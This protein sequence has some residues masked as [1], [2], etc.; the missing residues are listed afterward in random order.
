MADIHMKIGHFGLWTLMSAGQG[1]R[2]DH[3]MWV[4]FLSP[5]A[6]EDGWSLHVSYLLLFIGGGRSLETI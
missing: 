5:S 6:Y 1:P 2:K 3:V 4:M